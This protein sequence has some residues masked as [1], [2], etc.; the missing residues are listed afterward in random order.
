VTAILDLFDVQGDVIRAYASYGYAFSRYV[1]LHINHGDTGRAFV[2]A[3]MKKITSGANWDE[4]QNSVPKPM[5]TTNIAFS[6]E[7]LKALE[8]PRDSLRGFPSEFMMGMKARREI[9]GDDGLS[10]PEHWDPVWQ[11]QVHAL[12]SLNA[13]RPDFL[14]ERYQWLLDLIE[15]SHGGVTLMSGHCGDDGAQD[16]P[17]QSG[18]VLFDE[19][20]YPTPKEHFGYTDGITD[21]VFEGLPDAAQRVI[22]RGK[23]TTVGGDGGWTALATGEFLLGHIDEAHEYPKA[24]MPRTLSRNGTFMVY[25][26]LHE[27]VG[28]FNQYLEEQ[29]KIFP[30]GKELLA[31]KFVG[32]WRDNGAPLTDAWDEASKKAWD[33][34]FAKADKQEQDKML[35]GMVYDNDLHGVKCPF[36]AHVR[37]INPRASLQ[38]D[39]PDAFETPGALANRRRLLRRG[40]PYGASKPGQT[41][42]DGNHG[43]IIMLL[44]ASIERQFEFVQQQWINYGN[45]FME[46]NNK[47]VITGNHAGDGGVVLPVPAESEQPPFFLNKLPRFVETRGGE[48]FFIPSIMALNLIADGLVDPT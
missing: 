10:A 19:Q 47:E 12:V 20:G 43:I 5:A 35:A 30:G 33:E 22:G 18:N 27:N 42:D 45:D 39:I 23:Q 11:R 17:Y 34:R 32:R 36:S 24:P 14:E 46:A 1:C 28:T 9:I 7:G 6:Y 16:L 31:A 48:Y 26:K 38:F 37:R 44:N 2:Q 4:G 21:P 8:V 13:L 15:K 40:L 25:R 29:S 41:T 3:L